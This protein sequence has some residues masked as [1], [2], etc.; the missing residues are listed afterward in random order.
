VSLFLDTQKAACKNDKTCLDSIK[1]AYPTLYK[2]ESTYAEL[3]SLIQ[4]DIVQ[5]SSTLGIGWKSMTH[6][7]WITNDNNLK[8]ILCAIWHYLKILFGWLITAVALSMGAPFWYDLLR[9]V[10]NI[11]NELKGKQNKPVG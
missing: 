8:N 1:T 10:I 7:K 2:I 9:K 6:Y 5:A 3:D 4:N 11:K